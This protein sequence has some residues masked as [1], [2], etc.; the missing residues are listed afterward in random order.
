MAPGE[1]ESRVRRGLGGDGNL[2]ERRQSRKSSRASSTR[3][4]KPTWTK[5]SMWTQ[6]GE[7]TGT[8][9]LKK[10]KENYGEMLKERREHL[11]KLAETVGSDD[12]QTLALR[13]QY[14]M[15]HLAYISKDLLE[16]Q[17]QK[18]KAEARLKTR[19]GPTEAP[20]RHRPRRSPRP[21]STNGSIRIRASPASLPSS[22]RTKNDSTRRSAAFGRIARKPR[23]GPGAETVEGRM[24][25][26]PRNCSR[27][28]ERQLRPIAIRQLQEQDKTDQVA[29]GRWDRAGAGDARGPRETA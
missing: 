3:S 19:H 13:Q 1:S 27:A 20:R 15:E 26:R 14:A 4:R 11:R 8:T 2:L 25:Q 6:S 7:R 5:S 28:S 18:R 9:Q 12:R 24:W 21:K 22:P 29:Q 17:S 16:V 10:I 23:L